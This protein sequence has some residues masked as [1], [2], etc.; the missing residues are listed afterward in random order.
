MTADERT[1]FRFR[2]TPDLAITLGA[3]V[4]RPGDQMVSEA[5][6]LELVHHPSCDELGDYE[7]LLVDAMAG[8]AMLFARED[9][10]E[11]AW[12]IVEPILGNA[13]PVR[14]Y[15]QG[16]WGPEDAD[17]LTSAV[18]GWHAPAAAGDTA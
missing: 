4:K 18:G 9:A 16:S 11:A 1:T 6:D 2:L 14:E 12:A 7:R 13:T 8:D 5:A 15:A 3:R 17:T 10:V